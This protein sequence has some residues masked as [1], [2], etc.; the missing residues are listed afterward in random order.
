MISAINVKYTYFGKEEHTHKK[1]ERCDSKII[2][3]CKISRLRHSDTSTVI[4]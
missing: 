4:V 1:I 2:S 3:K